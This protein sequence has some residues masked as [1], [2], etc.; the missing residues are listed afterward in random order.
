MC[1]SRELL[2][3]LK[4]VPYIRQTGVL[5]FVF[6]LGL[7]FKKRERSL[8]CQS[9]RCDLKCV[10]LFVEILDDTG[11]SCVWTTFQVSPFAQLGERGFYLR[12]FSGTIGCAK[13]LDDILLTQPD[14][15][16]FARF[17]EYMH[18][19]AVYRSVLRRRARKKATHITP[20]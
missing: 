1:L 15:K 9:L 7:R 11:V 20:N 10:P 12:L 17:H 14:Y 19:G 16:S 5:K 6:A 2:Q 13:G 8:C 3:F 4:D 18:D